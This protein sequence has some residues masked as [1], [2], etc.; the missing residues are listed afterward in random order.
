MVA[1]VGGLIAF[2]GGLQVLDALEKRNQNLVQGV[3]KTKTTAAKIFYV[4]SHMIYAVG[5]IAVGVS[6]CYFPATMALSTMAW[7]SIKTALPYCAIGLVAQI[8]AHML[9]PL[10]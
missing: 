5:R 1:I 9:S 10:K 4:L 7:E 6:L 2:S 8:S 3:E